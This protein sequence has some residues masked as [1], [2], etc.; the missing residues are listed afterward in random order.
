MCIRDRKYRVD[1]NEI[2]RKISELG[3]NL[4]NK[5]SGF[6]KFL[7]EIPSKLDQFKSVDFEVLSAEEALKRVRNEIKLVP[8]SK[9]DLFQ[10]LN[11]LFEGKAHFSL[12]LETPSPDLKLIG[13]KEV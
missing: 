5:E 12:L 13:V 8:W 7:D 1:L 9:L 4:G 11:L 10:V 3:E 6:I 2:L